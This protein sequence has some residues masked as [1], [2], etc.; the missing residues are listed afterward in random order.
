M[1]PLKVLLKKIRSNFTETVNAGGITKGDR[2]QDVILWNGDRIEVPMKEI[3][4]SK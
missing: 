4:T 3:Q 2:S 1:A